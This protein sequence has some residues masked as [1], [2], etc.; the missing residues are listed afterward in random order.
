MTCFRLLCSLAVCMLLFGCGAPPSGQ[1]GDAS[2][3]ALTSDVESFNE[4]EEAAANA[5]QTEE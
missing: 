4:A 3:P 1:A 2:D 5:P